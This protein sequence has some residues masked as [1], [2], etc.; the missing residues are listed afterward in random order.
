MK[1][2][3][4]KR[5]DLVKLRNIFNL[6]AQIAIDFEDDETEFFCYGRASAYR[7]ILN[8]HREQEFTVAEEYLNERIEECK[9]SGIYE[10]NVKEDPEMEKFYMGRMI[11]YL[12]ILNDGD[13]DLDKIKDRLLTAISKQPIK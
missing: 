3:R 2:I 13:Q 10:R 11:S 4:V 5:R 6:C 1:E 7:W 12:N 8:N 9:T